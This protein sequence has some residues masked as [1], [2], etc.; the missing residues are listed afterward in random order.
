MYQPLKINSATP[1]H[2]RR[3]IQHLDMLLKDVHAMFRLP[4]KEEGLTAGC[5]Y[6]AAVF[7]LEIIGGISATLFQGT[8][9]SGKKFK[10]VVQNYY[11]WDLESRTD[12]ASATEE[13]YHFF[14]NPL[15]HA[16]G[17]GDRKSGIEKDGLPEDL[18]EKLELS[19]STPLYPTLHSMPAEG[20][21]NLNVGALYWGVRVMIT[22]LTD[23][24][25]MMTKTEAH[26][27]NKPGRT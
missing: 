20:S 14:R 10:A 17:M 26:L 9:G 2:T 7:L 25:A 6:A 8:G 21:L 18:L 3:L 23:D 27:S 11:P 1:K 5:N 15:A 22:R 13:L 12:N 16:L 24:V 19:T 4:L